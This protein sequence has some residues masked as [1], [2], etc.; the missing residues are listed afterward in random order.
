[1]AGA[2]EL[3]AAWEHGLAAGAAGRALLLH[4]LASP[5]G[6][7]ADL[8]SV[9]VG[10]RDR[11]LFALRRELFGEA[12]CGRLT[13]PDCGEEL[14]FDFAASAV[15]TSVAR[16]PEPV[17]HGRWLVR[18]RPPTPADLLHAARAGRDARRELL[19][20]CVLG[21]E[22]DGEAVPPDRLPPE[23]QAE[24]AEA[25][26]EADPAAEVLLSVPCVGC[27]GRVRAL[28]DIGAYLWAELDSWARGLLTEVHVLAGAYG[29]TEPEVLALSPTRRRHYLELV[30]HA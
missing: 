30:G 18:W 12:L 6:A 2:S 9:P 7:D 5:G 28:L 23:V 27:G 8:L 14:E 16:D 13:C 15:A 20:R 1:M 25:A 11:A 29:W 4:R 3:L 10:D 26:A 19:R 22:R 24:V 21:A 17:R